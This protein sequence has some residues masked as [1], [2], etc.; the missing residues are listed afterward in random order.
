M[1]PEQSSCILT[2]TSPFVRKWSVNGSKQ[3]T[4]KSAYKQAR[5]AFYYHAGPK[6]FEPEIFFSGSK[7]LSLWALG[8]PVSALEFVSK[9]EYL[10]KSAKNYPGS[11]TSELMRYTES[12]CVQLEP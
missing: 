5:K 8:K 4:L 6:N 3:T 10:Q 9:L 2:K 1:V 12:L 7:I 11:A